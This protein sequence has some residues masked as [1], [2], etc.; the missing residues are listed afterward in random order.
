MSWSCAGA[1]RASPSFLQ[2]VNKEA[3]CIVGH[4][5]S[6]L[7]AV[8]QNR[9]QQATKIA[10]RS[11]TP[12]HYLFITWSFCGLGSESGGV[13]VF[14]AYVLVRLGEARGVAG[15]TGVY[16]FPWAGAGV[17]CWVAFSVVSGV[18]GRL[19]VPWCCRAVWGWKRNGTDLP[20]SIGVVTART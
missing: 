14:V 15:V 6:A 13:F 7:W 9:T 16:W 2:S 19:D 17:G 1:T 20:S 8:I 18:G 3:D 4:K 5:I 12:H 10:T 11:L